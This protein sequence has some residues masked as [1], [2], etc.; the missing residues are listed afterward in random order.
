MEYIHT[1]A[2]RLSCF[3]LWKD[4]LMENLHLYGTLYCTFACY[5]FM[6][7]V[8]FGIAYANYKNSICNIYV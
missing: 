4:P 5:N 2:R 8:Y 7:V 1:I 3:S 6:N